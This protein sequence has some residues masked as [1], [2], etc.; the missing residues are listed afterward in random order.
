M[1]FDS[2]RYRERH[3]NQE[4]RLEGVLRSLS[5]RSAPL[6]QVLHFNGIDE[7]Y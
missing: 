5:E 1:E 7:N 6:N 4:N 3:H 2:C